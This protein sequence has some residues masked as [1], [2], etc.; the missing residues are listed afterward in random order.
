MRASL[1]GIPGAVMATVFTLAPGHAL[2]QAPRPATIIVDEDAG[3]VRKVSPGGDVT[4]YRLVDAEKEKPRAGEPTPVNTTSPVS[5]DA[6]QQV[7]RGDAVE[8]VVTLLGKPRKVPLD[9]CA[10]LL[11]GDE[12]WTYAVR[13]PAHTR[14]I[15]SIRDG[16][17]AGLAW[18]QNTSARPEKARTPAESRTGGPSNSGNEPRSNQLVTMRGKLITELSVPFGSLGSGDTTTTLAIENRGKRYTIEITPQTK[19]SETLKI[20]MVN[21]TGTYRAKGT[22]RGDKMV[23]TEIFEE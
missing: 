1:A 21:A 18:P 5:Y 10:Q 20:G 22:I 3:V 23:A 17:V 6:T 12:C 2:A 4:T 15:L 11:A 13:D 16:R 7:A 9:A 14:F 8:K 19:L